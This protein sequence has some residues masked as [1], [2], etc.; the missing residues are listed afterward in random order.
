[1]TQRKVILEAKNCI[2]HSIVTNIVPKKSQTKVRKAVETNKRDTD[3]YSYKN[4][5]P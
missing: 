2:S 3:F 4:L 5:S 1:M